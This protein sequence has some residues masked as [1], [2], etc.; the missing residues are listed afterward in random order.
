[1]LHLA[2]IAFFVHPLGVCPHGPTY[3]GCR[4]YN[5]WSGIAGSFLTSL[6]GWITAGLVFY[7]HANCHA[8][9]CPLVGRH[10]VEGTPYKTCRKHHPVLQ[11]G[12]ATAGEIADAHAEAMKLRYPPNKEVACG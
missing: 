1:M 10:P 8:K 4:G 11:G 7:L 2:N 9:R 3:I 6:P 12:A 5:F